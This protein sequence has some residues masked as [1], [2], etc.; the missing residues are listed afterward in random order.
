MPRPSRRRGFRQVTDR[1]LLARRGVALDLDLLVAGMAVEGAG[2]GKLAELVS[3]HVFGDEHR[4]ELA[5]VVNRERQTDGIGGNGRTA[6]PGAD[7]LL[8]L[9]G[10]GVV[11][12]L[13]EVPVDERTLLD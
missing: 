7:D 10:D 1:L 9:R 2:R 8:A 3:H 6:R 5:P 4:D 11:D 13:D 12:L